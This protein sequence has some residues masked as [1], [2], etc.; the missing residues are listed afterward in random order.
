MKNLLCLLVVLCFVLLS[1]DNIGV[2]G[3]KKQKVTSSKESFNDSFP[4]AKVVSSSELPVCDSTI[5]GQLFFLLDK[6]EFKFCTDAVY[7]TIDITGD[8]GSTGPTGL[9]GPQGPAGPASPIAKVFDGNNIELGYVIDMTYASIKVYNDTTKFLYDMKWDGNI[10][11]D[12]SN[13][14]YYTQLDCTGTAYLFN[15]SAIY[16]KIVVQDV[17]TK[18]LYKPKNLDSYNNVIQTDNVR[19]LSQIYVN[20][21]Y[22]NYQVDNPYGPITAVELVEVTKEECGIPETVALPLQIKYQ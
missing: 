7:E 8:K 11:Y 10:F 19:L 1:C 13:G 20:G 5:Q 18:K 3:S 15:T 9:G 17:Y 6:K 4:D 14:I 22:H 16:G 21:S 2:Q 12:N